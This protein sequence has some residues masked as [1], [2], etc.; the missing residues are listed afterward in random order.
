MNTTASKNSARTT[1]SP[2]PSERLAHALGVLAQTLPNPWDESTDYFSPFAVEFADSKPMT[3]ESLGVALGIG[4]HFHLDLAAVD[5]TATGAQMGDA[6]LAQGFA[7]LDTV[8][9]ATL[10]NITRVSARAPG[11]TRV[12]TW[13]LGRLRGGWLVGLRTESTET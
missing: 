12:R 2:I 6:V 7:L 1:K 3:A 13:V 10:T 5:L 8:M 9:K 11:I 4:A